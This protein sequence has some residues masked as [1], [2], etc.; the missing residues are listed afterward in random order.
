MKIVQAKQDHE[1][2]LKK[3]IVQVKKNCEER[4]R[5]VE[6]WREKQIKLLEVP[7]QQQVE[8]IEKQLERKELQQLNMKLGMPPFHFTMSNFN[9]L[10]IKDNA[11]HPSI[12]S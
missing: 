5:V 4:I 12:H 2:T 3:L 9:E 6:Q 7:S 8:R 11:Q 10:I 1:D